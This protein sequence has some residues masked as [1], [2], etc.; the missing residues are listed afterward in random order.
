MKGGV[1]EEGGEGGRHCW[2]GR[3]G[4]GRS[5]VFVCGSDGKGRIEM[6]RFE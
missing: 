6:N 1:G 3:G 2:S 5:M 4:G